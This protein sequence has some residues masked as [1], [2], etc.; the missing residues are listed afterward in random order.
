MAL[1]EVFAD[2]AM[3][4]PE[5][6][7]RFSDLQRFPG[8]RAATLQRARTQEPLDPSTLRSLDVPTLIIWGAKDRW[9]PVADAL[10]FQKDIR[11]SH[12]AIFPELGH[13]P[14]EENPKATD[15]AVAEFLPTEPPAPLPPPQPP[16]GDQS[17]ADQVVAPAI[18]PEKD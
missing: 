11:R 7:R 16:S 17:T 5:R 15:A 4:T 1:R 12:L 8:N 13:D 3:V 10:R 18:V 2:P 9:V 6:V 14:M